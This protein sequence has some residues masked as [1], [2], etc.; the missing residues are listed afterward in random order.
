MCVVLHNLLCLQLYAI[1]TLH[2]RQGALHNIDS[3]LEKRPLSHKELILKKTV[4]TTGFY[5]KQLIVKI[6]YQRVS[7]TLS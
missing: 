6:L 2:A 1:T 7:N 4:V 5:Q 3:K